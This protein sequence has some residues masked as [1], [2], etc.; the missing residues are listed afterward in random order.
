MRSGT[1]VLLMAGL[2]PSWPARRDITA[3]RPGRYRLAHSRPAQG[4]RG[5]RRRIHRLRER[6]PVY[7]SPTGK[8]QG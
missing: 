6:G 1:R 7:G 2:P 5:D 4:C 8:D 3:A